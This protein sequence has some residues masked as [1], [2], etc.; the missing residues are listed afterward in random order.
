VPI[1]RPVVDGE[2]HRGP[3]RD[4]I[5]VFEII[6]FY[7]R[8]AVPFFEQNEFFMCLPTALDIARKAKD[9]LAQASDSS[10]PPALPF[11]GE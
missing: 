1:L 4:P 8:S 11:G 5:K 2:S 10:A 9:L 3:A 7:A 6:K